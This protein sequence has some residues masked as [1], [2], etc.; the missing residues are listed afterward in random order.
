MYIAEYIARNDSQPSENEIC[1]Y[2]KE[3]RKYTNSIDRGKIKVPTEH[4][5]QWL[6]FLF[7]PFPYNIKKVL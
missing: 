6:F 7:H 4:T 2:Y 1:F 5:C 3:Y